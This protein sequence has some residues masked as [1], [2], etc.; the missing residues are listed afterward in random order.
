MVSTAK[1]Y[2]GPQLS[3]GDL[4]Q[5]DGIGQMKAIDKFDPDKRQRLSTCAT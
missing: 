4:I 3:I 5:E 2:G 1:R